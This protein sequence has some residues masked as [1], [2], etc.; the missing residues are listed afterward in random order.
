MKRLITLGVVLVV[1]FAL[2][3]VWWNFSLSPVNSQETKAKTFVIASGDGVREIAKK[4]HDQKLIRDQI[5]FFILVKKLGIEKQIQAGSYKLSLSMTAT[6]LAKK[7]TLG[8]EDIWITIPEGLRSEQILEILAEKRLGQGDI[9]KWRADEGKYFPETY[10]IPKLWNIDQIRQ[11]LRAMF[12][13]KFDAKLTVD[14]KAAGLTPDEVVTLASIIERETQTDE[15]MPIVAGIL[16]SRLNDDHPLQADATIHYMLGNKKND[17]WP[18]EILT[19]DLKIPSPYN[20]YLNP[21]LPPTPI[22]NPGLTSI[23][24]VIYPTPSDYYYYISD[25]KG[26]MHYAKTLEEH[27]TNVVKYLR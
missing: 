22:G 10:L 16:L 1:M 19:E 25:K 9:E 26:K 5:A 2:L 8:T 7:L 24:A 12:G 21:G 20:T 27:N 17:W 3:F 14:A 23:K 18:K 13:Q 15:D 6:D 11:H 4:L